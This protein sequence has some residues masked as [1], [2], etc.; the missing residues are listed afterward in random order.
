M[1]MYIKLLKYE[2]N[3]CVI[4]INY[5]ILDDVGIYLTHI[6]YIIPT[7]APSIF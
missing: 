7:F 3:Y 2:I 5:I 4:I 1:Y 6:I